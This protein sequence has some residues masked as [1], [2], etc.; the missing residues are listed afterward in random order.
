MKYIAIFPLD[1]RCAGTTA[2]S[3]ACTATNVI[4][5]A[6]ASVTSGVGR[7]RPRRPDANGHLDKVCESYLKSNTP[8]IVYKVTRYKVEL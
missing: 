8:H 7:E 4:A 6:H 5:T 3:E 2:L 1:I